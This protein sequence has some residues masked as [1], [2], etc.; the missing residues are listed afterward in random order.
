MA[1]VPSATVWGLPTARKH[2]LLIHGLTSSSHTWHRVA[3][4]LAA[5]GFLVT[6][7]N[8][9]GHGLRR[10]PD[11][12]MD[13]IVE[14]LRPYL[15]ARIYDL[16]IGHSL[17]GITTLSLFPHLSQSHPTAILIVD[18]PLQ[19]G[20]EKIAVKDA[21]FSASCINI[22]GAS[23]YMAK[24]PLWTSKDAIYRTRDPFGGPRGCPWH[25]QAKS[26]MGL[27]SLPRKDIDRMESD[28]LNFGS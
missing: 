4:S 20:A 19:Q 12:H 22:K 2:A 28:R 25:L 10:A 21:T 5:Q 27:P 24:N 13:S 6:A 17:C 11:Y 1:S 9:I 7:P 15:S 8:L 18:S 16:I 3:S 23:A 14:D 26:T